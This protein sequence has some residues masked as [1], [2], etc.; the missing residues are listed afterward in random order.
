MISKG[1]KIETGDDFDYLV[2]SKLE[3]F[4][5]DEELGRAAE[6]L[7]G[8]TAKE[9]ESD[10]LRPQAEREILAGRLYLRGEKLEDWLRDAKAAASVI[11]FSPQFKWD[12]ERVINSN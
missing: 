2:S 10:L 9:F 12:G 11:I 7:Y 4:S 3:K 6:T 1:A 5:G 8:L